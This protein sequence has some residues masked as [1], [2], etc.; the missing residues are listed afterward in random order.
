MAAKAP[1]LP[2]RAVWSHTT[3][4]TPDGWMV[5]FSLNTSGEQPG[6]RYQANISNGIY[7]VATFFT[8]KPPT[9]TY[10]N[11]LIDKVRHELPA[12][13]ARHEAQMRLDVAAIV[14][15]VKVHNNRQIDGTAREVETGN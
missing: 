4:R 3:Y 6:M 5:G 12:A 9:A 14:D 15:A 11:T 1:A 10:A 8:R 13:I 2:D 7:N